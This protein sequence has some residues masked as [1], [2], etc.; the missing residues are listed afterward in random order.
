MY[1][2]F[3]SEWQRLWNK[4][5]TWL[6]FL[7][8]PFIIVASAKYYLGVNMVK[9]I[10]S[11]EYTSVYNFPVAAMQEQLVSAF[12]IIVILLIVLSVTHEYR[13][14]QIRMVL[15]RPIKL[16]S[17][18]IAK[19]LV[20]IMVMFIYL[21]SYLVLSFIIGKMMFQELDEIS[22]FYTT[23]K[24]SGFDMLIYTLKYY[25]VSFITLCAFSSVIF[26]IATISKSVV[27]SVGG[28]LSFLLTSAF[29]PIIMQL[30]FYNDKLKLIK[31][32]MLSII[33]IQYQGI[34]IMIGSHKMIFYNLLVLFIYTILFMVG[35]YV[36]N[37]REDYYI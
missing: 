18:F 36:V 4:K 9:D 11:P 14:G 27:L 26:F 33:Q 20:I 28:S 23:C 6:C 16:S 34:A 30:F 35:S 29:Y 37:H 31:L 19:C 22:V 32:Q 13:S 8:I 25:L 15:V 17:I 3:I 21:L 12:N 2:L 5:S 1:K 24:F 7:S 10:T